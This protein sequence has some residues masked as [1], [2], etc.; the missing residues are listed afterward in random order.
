MSL[1]QRVE[2][3]YYTYIT[4]QIYKKDYR[5]RSNTAKDQ[6]GDVL[7]DSNNILNR[8]R[9]YIQLL[10]VQEREALVFQFSPKCCRKVQTAYTAR[11]LP[12]SKINYPSTRPKKCSEIHY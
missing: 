4:K 10:N 9:K 7:A 1:Q 3:E 5:P 12:N 8:R 6:N 11:Y 2:Q